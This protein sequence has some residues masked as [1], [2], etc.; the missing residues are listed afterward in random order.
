MNS[1]EIPP[2]A[3]L[4]GV[5]LELQNGLYFFKRLNLLTIKL[6]Q[7]SKIYSSLLLLFASFQ[8]ILKVCLLSFL[9][10]TFC[11]V[12]LEKVL[13]YLSSRSTSQSIK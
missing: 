9:F 11:S 12:Q 13:L 6:V 10:I 4:L 3:I 7:S 8:F 1:K 2:E 5:Y